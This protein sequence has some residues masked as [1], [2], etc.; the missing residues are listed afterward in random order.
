MMNSL[1]PLREI[2]TR[3]GIGID[4]AIRDAVAYAV[5]H[6]CSTRFKFNGVPITVTPDSDAVEVAMHYNN[7]IRSACATIRTRCPSCLNTSLIIGSN[8][9][10]VCGF[11]ECKDPTAINRIGQSRMDQTQDREM[12]RI[13]EETHAMLEPGGDGIGEVSTRDFIYWCQHVKLDTLEPISNFDI[14]SAKSMFAEWAK[15]PLERKTISDQ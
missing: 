15:A 10:L 5:T 7:R 4:E 8:G 13:H 12:E 2:E 3:L 14:E 9:E 11:L 1:F 6:Q